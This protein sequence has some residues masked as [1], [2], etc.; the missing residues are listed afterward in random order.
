MIDVTAF[1]KK[2]YPLIKDLGLTVISEEDAVIESMKQVPQEIL[3][4]LGEEGSVSFLFFAVRFSDAFGTDFEGVE[5]EDFLNQVQSISGGELTFSDVKHDVSEETFEKGEGT[6]EVSFQCS[7]KTYHYTAVFYYDWFDTK[8][9]S[10]LNQVFEELGM[11]KRLI[12]FGDM[13]GYLITYQKPEFC[14]IFKE[15]F[16]MLNADIA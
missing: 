7:G 6:G 4:D 15:K 10:F 13:N 3:E 11:E 14:R 16:P 9:L 12:V 8:F 2:Y 5:Y 1:V